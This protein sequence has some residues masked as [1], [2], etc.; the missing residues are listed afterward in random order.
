MPVSFSK[1]SGAGNDFIMVD[2]RDGILADPAEFARVHCRRRFDVGADGVMLIEGSDSADIAIR[3]I[4]A[5]GSE[6]EMCGNGARCA[7]MFACR[8]G[9]APAS[10][11]MDS[12][13]G[14]VSARVEG[15]LVTIGLD[16]A[17]GMDE[18]RELAILDTTLV[19]H[20][21]EFGVPHAVVFVE[22]AD[23]VDVESLGRAIRYHDAFAPR[24]TNA[25]FAQ[26][27]GPNAIRV[28]TYERGVEGE[29]FACGTGS[30]S[31]AI[32]SHVTGAVGAP[33]VEV[34]VNGG[35]LKV[36]F[37]MQ[38]GQARQVRLTGDAVTVCE[39][40]IPD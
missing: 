10:M 28:R 17:A 16:G 6:A 14:P 19:V 37:R 36:D 20:W 8:K 34:A 13:A 15:E 26:V 11:V 30:C 35:L 31:A 33:P 21:I 38:D 18:P 7:A 23:A 4:N 3:V 2:N 39:A 22:D 9:I 27:T 40:V 32:I 29:T 25:N 5:D 24:G 1:M 12:V